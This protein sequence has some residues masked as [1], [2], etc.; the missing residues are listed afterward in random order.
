MNL[1]YPALMGNK[2]PTSKFSE[3]KE[4]RWG[5]GCPLKFHFIALF[6]LRFNEQK[7]RKAL[8]RLKFING[9]HENE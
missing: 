4:V 2:P 8:K 6:L 1:V 3:S 7:Y 5:S 9:G